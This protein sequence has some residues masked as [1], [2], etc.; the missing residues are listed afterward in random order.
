MSMTEEK[1]AAYELQACK[2]AHLLQVYAM[3]QEL[4]SF[5][6]NILRQTQD[7][8]IGLCIVTCITSL[9]L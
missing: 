8:L 5:T 2:V 6:A 9:T 1:L 4:K 7:S 3:K